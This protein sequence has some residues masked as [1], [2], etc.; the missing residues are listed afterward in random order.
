MNEYNIEIINECIENKLYFNKVLAFESPNE[1]MYISLVLEKYHMW[2]L[3]NVENINIPKSKEE[4]YLVEKLKS[5][6]DERLEV[7]IKYCLGEIY[8][9]KDKSKS[10]T[11]F[12]QILE[13]TRNL[14]TLEYLN[15]MAMHHISRIDNTIMENILDQNDV[16]GYEINFAN[17][18]RCL[19]SKNVK[20]E[21]IKDVGIWLYKHCPNYKNIDKQ[22]YTYFKRHKL[23]EDL[24]ECNVGAYYT[25]QD[26][27][28]I[29]KLIDSIIEIGKI[30]DKYLDIIIELLYVINDY[31]YIDLW[32]KLIK[33]MYKKINKTSLEKLLLNIDE[34]LKHTGLFTN[35]LE[36]E[37]CI[38][39]VLS[40]MYT[41]LYEYKG[42]YEFIYEYEKKITK[43]L[44]Y[45]SFQNKDIAHLYESYCNLYAI[46]NV[47]T[48]DI[49]I[50]VK[51]ALENMV[52]IDLSD[53]NRFYVGEEYPYE[54]LLN[55]LKYILKNPNLYGK[56]QENYFNK[57]ATE[58]KV[59]LYG[60]FS[61]GKSSFINS[62]LEEDILE[63]GDLP[64]TSTFTLVGC[65]EDKELEEEIK[66]SIPTKTVTVNNSFLRQNNIMFIDTPGFED[67]DSKQG[68]LS[69]DNASICNKFIVLL[70]ATRPLTASEY[71]RIKNIIEKIPEIKI[72]FILNKVDY[73]DEEEDSI[74]EIIEDTHIKLSKIM[75]GKDIN[76]YPY[77]C[78]LVKEGNT[79]MKNGLYN[80]ILKL[81]L[82]DKAGVRLDKV[83]ESIEFSK[84][85]VSE[86]I[87]KDNKDYEDYIC[88]LN[89]SMKNVKNTT[90]LLLDE[91]NKYITYIKRLIDNFEKNI[92]AYVKDSMSNIFRQIPCF[93]D[94]SDD[95]D[96]IHED[97]RNKLRES[98]DEWSKTEYKSFIIG[99]LEKLLK[100][101]KSYMD[102]KEIEV[103]GFVKRYKQYYNDVC[104][105][106][107]KE[108]KCNMEVSILLTEITKMSKEILKDLYIDLD[109]NLAIGF[110]KHFNMGISKPVFAGIS[111]GFSR[112][113]NSEN[114]TLEKYKSSIIEQTKDASIATAKQVI[115][116][117]HK[118]DMMIGNI[119]YILL[120]EE[121]KINKE[122]M[123]N[124]KVASK[125]IDI[126][127]GYINESES[128]YQKIE[129]IAIETKNNQNNLKRYKQNILSEIDNLNVE[130]IRYE[131]QI[132]NGIIY[133]DKELYRIQ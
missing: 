127:R 113:F 117:S 128:I 101:V 17:F 133:N 88:R 51:S 47:Y 93:I 37:N 83:T 73:I 8:I 102:N 132:Y 106:T 80:E 81:I 42:K 91:E 95:I 123:D 100:D 19:V 46:S 122:Y 71:N 49:D 40:D 23:Y 65:R 48:E 108:D 54:A 104:S 10:K 12:N 22:I 39:S 36:G 66:Y 55:N 92:V 9:N 58:S 27:G 126:L 63:E 115:D 56:I 99:S 114:E 68:Q 7:E 124:P 121:Y 34:T 112:L 53:V 57:K 38:V 70:D 3:K 11:Y 52:N 116:N 69:T 94:C 120:T 72:L 67:L 26:I 43:Y 20:N 24:I 64:T 60:M 4:S 31:E 35:E 105:T 86:K 28:Y 84:F 96:T 2:Y 44:L 82:S 98:V 79:M 14:D 59:M 61:S 87:D 5:C 21:L 1:T 130:L 103:D 90:K 119:G 15:K 131:K 50:S 13:K 89:E 97:V 32:A 76:I 30:S 29:D 129:N 109:G 62:L 85:K 18:N 77:S 74:E 110:N 6:K 107:L 16:I 41:D 78:L 111:K 33:V 45:A 118:I 125:Y 75:D 25:T